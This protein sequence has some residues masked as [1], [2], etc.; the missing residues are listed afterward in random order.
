MSWRIDLVT[1]K[2]KAAA[3]KAEAEKKAQA[4]LCLDELVWNA[5][6]LTK[7]FLIVNIDEVFARTK[8][9]EIL[10]YA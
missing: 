7:Y 10:P 8:E 1:A 5:T 3:E 4:A 9:H 6:H 2:A